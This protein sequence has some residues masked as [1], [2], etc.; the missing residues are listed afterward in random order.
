MTKSKANRY[1][2]SAHRRMFLPQFSF[3]LTKFGGVRSVTVV[4]HL[5]FHY[6]TCK[7]HRGAF[8]LSIDDVKNADRGRMSEGTFSA[9]LE[10]L[11]KVGEQYRH[12][13]SKA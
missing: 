5:F 10:G 9:L 12:P 3:D 13:C 11:S 4:F 1:S 6:N 7:V 8:V 2:E